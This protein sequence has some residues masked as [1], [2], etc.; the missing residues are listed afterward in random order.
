MSFA[1]DVQVGGMP[2]QPGAAAGYEELLIELCTLQSMAWLECP[3]EIDLKEG[4]GEYGGAR[5]F[6]I[7]VARCRRMRVKILKAARRSKSDC[8]RLPKRHPSGTRFELPC[9]A[10]GWLI[11]N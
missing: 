5:A 10:V 4:T 9:F 3:F 8:R 1:A 7:Q 6:V 2:G 11:S